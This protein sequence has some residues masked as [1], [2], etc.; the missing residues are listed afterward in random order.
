MLSESKFIDSIKR[1]DISGLEFE[2]IDSINETVAGTMR[3][4]RKRGMELNEFTLI[5]VAG[6]EVVNED[7]VLNLFNAIPPGPKNMERHRT[8]LVVGRYTQSV[9]PVVVFEISGQKYVLVQ[10]RNPVNL[11]FVESVE[12]YRDYVALINGSYSFE[13]YFN[14]AF[15]DVLDLASH[16]EITNKGRY[17]ENTGI[18]STNTH[19]CIC[20]LTFTSKSVTPRSLRDV[21]NN[22]HLI[23][24]KSIVGPRRLDLVPVETVRERYKQMFTEPETTRG[25]Y[26]LNDLLS[27]NGI[28]CLFRHLDR[29]Q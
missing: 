16:V 13:K 24:P 3:P 29:G 22:G 11:G 8:H 6:F 7:T 18:V 15:K 12:F 4:F 20:E 27:V 14:N 25:E 19:I 28:F 1:Y 5:N 21:L 23:D 2:P 9:M 26:Y 10:E 17:W